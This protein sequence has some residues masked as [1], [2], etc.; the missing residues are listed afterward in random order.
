MTKKLR[1]MQLGLTARYSCAKALVGKKTGYALLVLLFVL[2]CSRPLMAEPERKVL[3]GHVPGAV[4][5][6]APTRYL[7]A[8]NTLQLAIGLPLRNAQ[9]LDLLV[10]QLYDPTS[11]NY[12]RYLTPEEFTRQ[13]GPTEADYQVIMD[14]AKSKGLTVTLKHP[15]RI[16][17]DVAGTVANIEKAFHVTMRIYQHPQEA[18]EFYAPDVEPSVEAGVPILHISGLDNYFL[19]HPNLKLRPGNPTASVTPNSGSGPS[20]TY[21]GSDFRS[22]Y[23]PGTSLTGAGQTVG[24]LQFDGFYAS[25]IATYA[26]QAGLP[27]IPVTVVPVDG[28]VSIPGS[29]NSEVSLD[30]E[31]VMSMAPGVT[32]IYV[33]EAP[34]PSPW[35]D[36][37][38]A[39]ATHNPLPKQLSCSWGGGSA[40]ASAEQI[41]K[42][43]AAQ[44][45]SFFNATGDSDAFTSAIPFP[46][47]STN[48]TEVG[49]TTLSTG[50]GG[51]YS[52]ETVW[53]WGKQTSGYVGSSGGISTYYRIPSYQQGL[54]MVTNLGSTTMRNVPDVALTADNVYVVYNNGGTGTFGGTSCAAPLWAGFTALIN[55]Q[56]AAAGQ[57]SVGFLNP[58]LYTIGRG[59]SYT[60][61]FHDT[62]TG[63]NFS[64][65]SPSKFSAVAGYD[66]CTGWGTPN[67]TNLINS[68]APYP[69]IQTPPMSQTATNGNNAR[70]SVVAAGQPPFGYRWLFNGSNLTTGGNV[71]GITSNLLTIATVTLSNAGSYSVIVTNNYGSVT[72]S[73][74]T[75]TVVLL[76]GFN[77]QPTNLTAVAGGNAVFSAAV[78]GSSPLMFQWRQNGTNLNN[79]G[80]VTGATS[81]ALT[82]AAVTIGAAGNY[83]LVASNL[84]GAATSSVATLTVLQTPM[85]TAPPLAQTVQCGSNAT[86]SVTA[87]GTPPLNYQWSLDGLPLPGATNTTLWLTNVHLPSHILAVVVTNSYGSATSSVPLIVQD[88]LPPAITLIGS[89]P[90]YVELGSVF[91]D[92]GATAYDLCMG[93]VPVTLSGTVNTNAVSTNTLTY[94]AADG[95]GNT[96]TATRLV[97]V[98][99]ITAPTIL[100][101]FTNLTLAA[102]TNCTA[103]MPNVTG[104]NYILA[105]DLSGA[106]TLTQVPTNQAVLP[107][108]SHVVVI[109]VADASGNA[110][111]STNA[112]VVEDQT[113]PVIAV[114]PQSQTGSVGGNASFSVS[115]TACTPLAFQWYFANTALAAQTNS[116]L[117]LSNLT[118]SM[119]GNYYVTAAAMGGSVTSSVA[120]LTVVP[121]PTITVPPSAQTVQ[122]GSNATFSVTAAGTPPLNY[123]WSLD[124]LPL[125]GATNTTLWLTNVHLPSHILAVVVTNPYGSANSSVPLMVQDTLPPAITLIGSNPAY[126]ELGSAFIDPGATAYDLCMGAVPVTLSGTVNTNAV[127]TN[128]LTYTAA[129]GNGNT[130][131]ATRLVIVR[132]TTPPTILWSFTNLTVAAGTNCIATMPNVTG[133]N[134]ILA[135]DLSGALTLTQVPTNQAVLP[136]GSHVV[137]ITV[138]D[139]SGNTA[140]STNAI[141]VGDQT[142]P[143]IA[144]P[145]QSQT[146]SVGGNASFSVSATACTPLAF[147]WYFAN[148][149]LAAQ[150]NSLLTLS[151][152]TTS[153]AG[154]YFVTVAAAG[155]SVT[156][157]VVT[158]T[159]LLPPTI[160]VPPSA[161]TVQCGSNATF[162][163]T[164]AGTPPLNYQWSLDGL[165]LPGATNPTL[166]LTNVHL[167]SH[168]LAVVVTNSYGNATSSVPL[169]VQDTLPPAITLIGSNPAYVELGS[170]FIDA[171]AT[172]Y[173]LCMG[174]VPVTLSGT[175][176]TNAVSTN[177]LTYTAADGNGNTNTATRLVIV[178][179]T[180]PPSILWSFTNLTL[181]AGTN[182]IATMPD[183]TGTNYI[184]ATD[185]SG[186]LTLT[187]EPT[188]QAV[189]PLGTQVVVI[190]VADASGNA[191]YS[192]NAIV[193]GDQTPPVITVPPQSQTSSV[194]G[195]ASF[196]MSA[197]ACTPLAFQWY[198]AN[199]VLAT[200]TNSI[201]TLSN[202][203]TGAA[204]DYFVTVAAAGGSSTSA[205]ATLT[206][207]LLA[208]SI[209]LT[210]LENPAGYRYSLNFIAQVRPTNAA[211]TIQFFTNGTTFDVEP[212]IAGQAISPN[213]DSLPRGT[214]IVQAVYS[215]DANDLPA[216]N[217]LAQIV[218]N[219]PPE[220]AAAY[221]SR[222]AGNPLYIALTNLASYWSDAD[223]DTVSLAAVGVS[224]NGV[225]VTNTGGTL[226]YVNSNNVADQF[227]CAITDGWGGTNFQTVSISVLLPATTSVRGS[228]KNSLTLALTAAPGSTY[229]LEVTRDL[230]PAAWQPVATNTL[231]TDGVWQFV[232]D[233]ASNF[234]QGFYRFR[235]VP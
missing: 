24:L 218:T 132:D 86:F 131:T 20:G 229:I 192:T 233:Q 6:L 121:P 112:I 154:D 217:A 145:P 35:V 137:V 175:V 26:S 147:Q 96:N 168:I 47:D 206:V 97:I 83:T 23:V 158:L 164:A 178:R 116:I 43:M 150:T 136:L 14:F 179:D 80:N 101:S 65:S 2:A 34:N 196:S 39:M 223:G 210:S 144:V 37:L 149:A 73:T 61:N 41:F 42:Q 213:L 59:A 71:S 187:Q 228:P 211:G 114:P 142:P 200:Q 122:C 87:A 173:D 215:G 163:V 94:T 108:G 45:Q 221:Y 204:G 82:L 234:Q 183:V 11:L 30:I 167:P 208:S 46:S 212:L 63:N 127:S 57:A 66:L 81:N 185:L 90:A 230:F 64:S 148:A 220:A 25:D 224:T 55:Q 91:I 166:W 77:T 105:T 222:P 32:N 106:L 67:G 180:T 153:A 60:T 133:T 84:Y 232:D 177:T 74:A 160:T 75:L 98:R 115:A 50:T 198:F 1:F 190:T 27:T 155:G 118:T 194:G 119:A 53:N 38:N 12:R 104:T 19:P 205:V 197:T 113:P 88:T 28:G 52:S 100:W 128:T 184:L 129:D 107:L 193:V 186:P 165:P 31:M 130:N 123:Q 169:T 170:A 159:V 181:A 189:L 29:G 161:Q 68:L 174:A 3:P 152:L 125:P 110:A 171:G 138:A 176:N 21:R 235:L 120:T 33:F 162:S 49:G 99:D 17:L 62:T 22:A 151:N 69:S 36:L 7:P 172:A 157:S 92:P 195:N 8:T 109:T 124:G 135:T 227:V 219:H 9:E 188:N 143:V 13:F 70:F 226:L 111:Y 10:E 54:S 93:A 156:S 146:G 214:N 18:R 51:T 76:P 209:T 103:T 15:N 141:V 216:T 5:G 139:A 4:A 207:N 199:T 102:G 117:T 16:V 56:A 126:V 134:Y 79:G 40:N 89:N 95:N 78:S 72:S 140:Y 191:S 225:T 58:S 201:L 48:I 85:I 203:T 182:C 202:L 44:G 231:G